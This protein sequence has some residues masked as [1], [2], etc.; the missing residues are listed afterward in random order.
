MNSITLKGNYSNHTQGLMQ[1]TPIRKT[2]FRHHNTQESKNM[3]PNYNTNH[4]LHGKI[5]CQAAL[6]S[7]ET[8]RT[9]G[10]PSSV[11]TAN[12]IANP[13]PAIQG[14]QQ[15]AT[16]S[17]LLVLQITH[18]QTYI[19]QKMHQPPPHSKSRSHV[20]QQTYLTQLSSRSYNC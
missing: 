15:P 10:Q 18:E 1:D 6:Q 2:I 5:I 19:T 8:S 16:G 13:T 17:Y 4:Q 7:T 11:P 9:D 14:Q 20:L 3:K 12:T